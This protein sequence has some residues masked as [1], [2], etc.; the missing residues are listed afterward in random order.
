MGNINTRPLT[1]NYG[2]IVIKN[3]KLTGGGINPENP[4]EPSLITNG[5]GLCINRGTATLDNGAFVMNNSAN[6]SGGGVYIEDYGNL[7]MRSGSKICNNTAGSNGDEGLG[8]G[9]YACGDSDSQSSDFTMLGGEISGNKCVGYSIYN[10]NYYFSKGAGVYFG[11]IAYFTMLGGSITNNV[12]EEPDVEVSEGQTIIN[13]TGGGVYCDG[14]WS[15]FSMY[16][17]EISNN[18]AAVA[19]DMYM[20]DYYG[21]YSLSGTAYISN[22]HFNFNNNQNATGFSVTNTLTTNRTM[23]LTLEN[24]AED[25]NTTLFQYS[26]DVRDNGFQSTRNVLSKFNLKNTEYS[27]GNITENQHSDN[28]STWYVYSVE[29][30]PQSK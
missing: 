7:M 25:G 29:L 8:G 21:N 15:Y 12:I 28:N 2:N 18:T 14:Y 17:G 23:D 11:S 3:L 4:D 24:V 5:G 19:S 6:S 10:N 27:I 13:G 26:T 16:G 30:V 9:V 20:I 1:V 22:I